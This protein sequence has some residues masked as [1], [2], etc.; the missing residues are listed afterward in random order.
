MSHRLDM[1]VTVEGVET[2]QQLSVLMAEVK[3]DLVQ[4]FLF[5]AA[6]TSSGIE[7]MSSTTWQFGDNRDDASGSRPR[8]SSA[9]VG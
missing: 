1:A 5:G 8:R 6:V 7:A 4:G 9:S 2:F 3:P